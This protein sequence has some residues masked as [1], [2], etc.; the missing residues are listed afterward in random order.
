M[1]L[2]EGKDSEGRS[3]WIWVERKANKTPAIIAHL[4]LETKEW[5][6]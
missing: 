4:N 3:N 6:W 1:Q 5:E 2:F